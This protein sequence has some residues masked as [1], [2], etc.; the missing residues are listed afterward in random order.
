MAVFYLIIAVLAVAGFADSVWQFW[1]GWR[2]GQTRQ[3]GFAG[4]YNDVQL[5]RDDE[6]DRLWFFIAMIARA[7][8][9]WSTT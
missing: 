6:D 2:T 4:L 1:R 3:L 5:D 9:W 7:L 8:A